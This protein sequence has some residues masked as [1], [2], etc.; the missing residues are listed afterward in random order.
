MVAEVFPKC[1][2][3]DAMEKCHFNSTILSQFQKSLI[4]YWDLILDTRHNIRDGINLHRVHTDS[5][6]ILLMTSLGAL[7]YMSTI[8]NFPGLMER[9]RLTPVHYLSTSPLGNVCGSAPF[10]PGSILLKSGPTPSQLLSA[11]CCHAGQRLSKENKTSDISV[12]NTIR[13]YNHW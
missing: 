8:W 7:V 3:E 9:T 6:R 13:G 10:Q 5:Y 4:I 1:N 2:R 11:L 12:K